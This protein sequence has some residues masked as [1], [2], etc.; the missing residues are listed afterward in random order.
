[1][2]SEI[3]QGN[4]NTI[5]LYSYVEFKKQNKWAKERKQRQTKNETINQR[6][7]T[8]GY[9]KDVSKGMSEIGEGD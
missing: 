7:Q 3:S 6:Q 5:W 8:N 2:L 9:R 4:T 1:M